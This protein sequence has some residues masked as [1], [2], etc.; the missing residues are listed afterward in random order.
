M[1]RQNRTTTYDPPPPMVRPD[2][3]AYHRD[4]AGVRVNQSAQ[5]MLEDRAYATDPTLFWLWPDRWDVP[6]NKASQQHEPFW[7]W[8]DKWAHRTDWDG[9]V[10]SL[11]KIGGPTYS[12]SMMTWPP[13]VLHAWMEG[14]PPRQRD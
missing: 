5:D 3:R 2:H 11:R 13:D 9:N 14:M 4:A 10:R 8:I 7:L 12:G 1:G 6:L